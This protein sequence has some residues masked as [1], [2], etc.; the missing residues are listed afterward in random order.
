M[1]EQP[2][3][4]SEYLPVAVPPTLYGRQSQLSRLRDLLSTTGTIWLQGAPGI[5]RRALAAT[6][7]TDYLTQ[8]GGVLWFNVYHDDLG[9]LA[10]R[11]MR[12]YGVSSL[13]SDDMA[14][15]IELVQ[16]LLDQNRPLVVIEG[17]IASGVVSQFLE[18]C[19]P[20]NLPL[21]MTSNIAPEGPWARIELGPLTDRHAEHLYRDC[22]QLDETRRT[23]LLAPLLDYVEGHPLAIVIAGRQRTNAGIT[24]THFAS[25][26]PKAPSGPENRALGVYAAAQSLLDT[27]SKGLFLLMGSLFVDRISLPLLHKITGIA[28]DTLSNFLSS[29]I[30]KAL[31]EEITLPDEP[32]F[33]RIH[34]LGRIYARRR[35]KVAGQLDS[36][37]QRILNGIHSFVLEYTDTDTPEVYNVLARDMDHVLG[38]A[39]YAASQKDTQ[40]LESIFKALGKHGT[41]N[42]IHARGY[43]SL[44]NRLGRLMSGKSF[45]TD[46]L[47][48]DETVTQFS[49][50]EIPEP[51]PTPY[52]TG[53]FPVVTD[54]IDTRRIL[55]MSREAL[56][57]ALEAALGRQDVYVAS[58]LSRTL[59]QWY[60]KRE[61]YEQSLQHFL[62]SLEQCEIVGDQENLMLV[63]EQ[64]AET[65][66]KLNRPQDA[67]PHVE[68]ALQIANTLN[69]IQRQGLLLSVLG[70]I[71]VAQN[72]HETA[73]ETYKRSI[74]LLQSKGEL[75]QTGLAMGKAATLY[76]DINELQDATVVLAQSAALFEK[77]GRRDLQG[78]ALGNLGTTFGRLG[79]WKE[80]GYRHSLALQIARENEDIEEERFQLSNLAYV[81]EAESH[82]DWA[83]HYNRQALYLSLIE[84]HQESMADITL[85]L[86]RVL[87]MDATA[88]NLKQAILLLEKSVDLDP[89]DEAV[90]L[91]G[92]AQRRLERL[93]SAG[94]SVPPAETDLQT[95]A[96]S[97]YD[98]SQ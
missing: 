13:S 47:V 10:N 8:P 41:Q 33:Y 15:Q 60:S 9:M 68:R 59:G 17:P 56:E 30:D 86:G 90:R 6:I 79:R 81:C 37:R 95:Y 24:S 57:G 55:G 74:R 31:C 12:A 43:Q 94:Y 14:S 20:P 45:Q 27:P 28:E 64:V 93:E 38:A 92:R 1:I 35:L 46:N 48:I 96:Q 78:Q 50:P 54:G 51:P 58:R 34:D 5:G 70:D 71:Q 42:V 87:L 7:A 22:A 40:T 67:Q 36:I 89:Q 72:D 85:S 63:L 49:K 53:E 91:L 97:A 21:I 39:R 66:L 19:V 69:D 98:M 82:I 4:S 18:R 29:L 75:V 77:A 73:L 44:Y 11:V 65:L 84:G 80:A 88:T 52:A 26:L 83:I 61:N 25:L 32:P 16:A 76:M 62:M 23:A 2:L 3:F